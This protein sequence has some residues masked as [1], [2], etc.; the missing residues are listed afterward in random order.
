MGAHRDGKKQSK[1]SGKSFA[2]TLWS[3]ACFGGSL[4]ISSGNVSNILATFWDPFPPTGLSCPA[5]MWGFVPG[6]I[7][8]FCVAPVS[9]S[10]DALCEPSFWGWGLQ[11]RGVYLRESGDGR[12]GSSSQMGNSRQDVFYEKRR[13]KNFKII[14]RIGKIYIWISYN[15]VV[16]TWLYE[17]N[18][19]ETC[20]IFH[21]N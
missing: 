9:Y 14:F 18:F 8:S 19:N 20:F 15:Q 4:N 11:E 13:N 21:G 7:L 17:I 2:Y 1:N 5:I 3:L 10:V 16:I 12:T 6:L